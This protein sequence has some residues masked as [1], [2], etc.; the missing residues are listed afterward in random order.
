MKQRVAVKRQMS[1]QYAVA[2]ACTLAVIAGTALFAYLNLA[3]SQDSLAANKHFYAVRPGD[4]NDS[5]AWESGVVPPTSKIKH[6][7]EILGRVV[8]RGHLSYKPGSGNTLIVKDTLTIDGNLTLGN[9]SNLT[10][11][12]GG[13]LM[14]AGDFSIEKKCEITNYGLIAVG[15]NCQ[16]HSLA[17][18]DYVGDSS[19][20]FHF[21]E[22]FT[23]DQPIHFGQTAEDLR[24]EHTAIYALV[25]K[26]RDAL[27]PV[28]FSA[29]LQQ[30][31]VLTQWLAENETVYASFA[32]EKS[33]DGAVFEEIAVIADETNSMM[34]ARVTYTDP[35]PP[36]GVSYY[37]LKRT[38]L[39]DNTAYS[40][41][42]MIANWGNALSENS[43]A[44]Q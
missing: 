12:E 37:R 25:K 5:S 28:F 14:V 27:K 26:K 9:T 31:R 43:S 41:L 23:H 33:T 22:V 34:P 39:D 44:G 24:Q 36:L 6:T 8:R 40:Q 1:L 17:Q 32:V 3:N 35:P 29:T 19:Q 13:V 7:I 30:G 15:G 4:W 11:N 18:I 38:G 42:I 21:G 2:V 10:V 16:I 20:L